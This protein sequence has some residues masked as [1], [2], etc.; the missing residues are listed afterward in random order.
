VTTEAKVGAF[1]LV[2]VSI[3]TG[4]LVY[5]MTV[6]FRGGDVPYRTYLRF[7]GGLEP[8]ASV[9]FG[10]IHAGKVTKVRAWASDPTR[11]EILLELKEGTPVNEK[12]VA[13]LGS[14]SIMS[15]PAL[16]ISTGSNAAPRL[17]PGTL[18][19]SQ[20]TSSL[21]DIAGKMTTLADNANGLVL[22]VQGEIGG[23]ST[24]TRRLL[25]N[26]NSVT[27][28]AN[29]KRIE[30]LLQQANGLLADE[31]PKIDHIADQLLALTQHAMLRSLK[32]VP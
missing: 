19:P 18:I 32:P 17:G 26:L 8:G 31:R 12:C 24:D 11:I 13:K 21:D 6:Q 14:L 1:V 22:Q 10:G 27:G 7:A 3:L 30:T 2:C 15:E 28:Q 5:L 29:Q 25:A 9:L 23:I 16:V 20:E 4:T